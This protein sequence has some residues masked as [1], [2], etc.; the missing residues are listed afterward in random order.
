MYEIYCRMSTQ[1]A[2]GV[3]RAIASAVVDPM[4][5]SQFHT[6]ELEMLRSEVQ[7]AYGS[8]ALADEVMPGAGDAE[9]DVE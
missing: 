7:E 6:E 2:M 3:G 1:S 5:Q 4:E 8:A 9:G